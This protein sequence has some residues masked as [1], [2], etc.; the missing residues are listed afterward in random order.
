[1]TSELHQGPPWDVHLDSLPWLLLPWTSPLEPEPTLA[2]A[3][4]I[5]FGL[6]GVGFR[7]EEGGVCSFSG[8]RNSRSLLVATATNG[9][10]SFENLVLLVTAAQLPSTPI[11]ALP[12]DHCTW[13]SSLSLCLSSVGKYTL[14]QWLQPT[15]CDSSSAT[16]AAFE[17]PS[18]WGI[19]RW[20]LERP[21]DTTPWGSAHTTVLLHLKGWVGRV[22]QA[23]LS[24]SASQ[25]LS[26]P[27]PWGPGS[28]VVDHS[29]YLLREPQFQS[30]W[31][32]AAS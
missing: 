25:A 23:V 12:R 13:T 21:P 19:R 15:D 3:A 10:G 29:F 18:L 8:V 2:A 1:M 30:S 32:G 7:G 14:Q 17:I 27:L 5:G 9:G 20:I 24:N 26:W 6:L 31:W 28:H 11:M 22:T 4:G 16:H